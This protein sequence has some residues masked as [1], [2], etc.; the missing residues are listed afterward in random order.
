M[1]AARLN[2]LFIRLIGCALVFD[3]ALIELTTVVNGSGLRFVIDSDKSEA[4]RFAL[5]PLEVIK[6]APVVVSLDGVIG[7]A[8]HLELVIDEERT[9]GVVVVTGSVFGNEYRR[10]ILLAELVGKLN[11]AL[12]VYL[13]AKVV[14]VAILTNA[15]GYTR[16][17]AA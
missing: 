8:Y 5:T 2:V 13:P 12:V 11:K 14:N 16:Y 4:S 3:N 9:E 7:L 1:I 6:E 15:V 17:R 10:L